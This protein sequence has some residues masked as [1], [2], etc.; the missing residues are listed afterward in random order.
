MSK[1]GNLLFT[2]AKLVTVA[3]LSFFASL[4]KTKVTLDTWH[5]CNLNATSKQGG[6]KSHITSQ[7]K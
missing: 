1:Q 4:Y 7:C 6:D 5:K 3:S 2:K